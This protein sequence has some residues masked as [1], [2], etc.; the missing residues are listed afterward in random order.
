MQ[1]KPFLTPADIALELDISTSTVMRKIH[2]GE[3][4]AIAVSDRIYRIPAASFELYKAGRLRNARPA[5][6][7]APRPRPRIGE[8]EPKP[9]AASVAAVQRA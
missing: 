5:P 2:A 6:V 1:T 9:V 7:G 8:G 4:P 3:I